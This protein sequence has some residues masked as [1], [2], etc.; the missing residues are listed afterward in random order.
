MM[1][2]KASSDDTA[3]NRKC[4]TNAKIM[5]NQSRKKMHRKRKNK[6]PKDALECQKN[7]K[8]MR[9][10]RMCPLNQC[11][12]RTKNAKKM[13]K[14]GTKN[15]KTMHKKCKKMQSKS[16]TN[17]IKNVLVFAFAFFL[18]CICVFF[19]SIFF[20]IFCAFP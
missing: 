14:K 1:Y 20:C 18:L 17:A 9:K 7:A 3:K 11:K 15:A 8:Q 5:Q 4:I 16:K 10:K 19:F 6:S 2:A 12:K 13:H